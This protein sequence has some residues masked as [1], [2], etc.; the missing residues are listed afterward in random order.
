MQSSVMSSVSLKRHLGSSFSPGFSGSFF[1]GWGSFWGDPVV[2]IGGRTL[3]RVIV[4]SVLSIAFFASSFTWNAASKPAL[5]LSVS[6]LGMMWM[7]RWGTA[8]P[9]AS[10]LFEP[11]L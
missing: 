4:L 7:W 10:P 6:Y 2:F 8:W 1:C 3:P 11:M 9:A 5:C